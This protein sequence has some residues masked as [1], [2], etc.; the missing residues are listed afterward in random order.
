MLVL[1]WTQDPGTPAAKRRW[2]SIDVGT[3][4]YVSEDAVAEWTLSDF[5]ILISKRCEKSHVS[6]I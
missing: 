6:L 4:I 5:D 1:M 3:E 2:T